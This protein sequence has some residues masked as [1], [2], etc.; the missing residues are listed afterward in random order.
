MAKAAAE[1]LE[2]QNVRATV[3]DAYS[4]PLRAER[5]AETLRRSGGKALV[6]EDNYGGLSGAVAEVAANAGNLR[7]AALSCQRIPKSA[8]TVAEVLDYCGVGAAQIARRA[9]T[10]L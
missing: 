9:A 7:V 8:R 2:K 10:M 3:I 5:L 4:L 1:L 6:V